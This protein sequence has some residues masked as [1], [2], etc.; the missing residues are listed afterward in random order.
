MR[1]PVIPTIIVVAACLTMIRLGFWQLDRAAEKEDMLSRYHSAG[2][3]EAEVIWPASEVEAEERL[4][5]RSTLLCGKVISIRSAAGRSQSGQSG[6]AHIAL[7]ALEGGG[8]AEAALGWSRDPIPPQ[9]S[10]AHV[11]G[12]IAPPGRAANEGSE[13]FARLVASQGQAGLEP[14]ARPDPNDL[15]NNHLAYAWQWFL[16]S[17]TAGVIYILALRGRQRTKA[18]GKPSG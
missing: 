3:V 10:A 17:L 8:E 18:R 13:K 5:R 4:Y 1:F 16:F 6:W 9:W 7:C 15:P 14:L 12:F 11:A 2:S